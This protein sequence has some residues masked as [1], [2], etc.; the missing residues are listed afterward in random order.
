MT[1]WRFDKP[2]FTIPAMAAALDGGDIGLFQP[3]GY[4]WRYR[5][6]GELLT[7]N[8]CLANGGFGFLKPVQIL[9]N[10]EQLLTLR[11]DGF[12]FGG[13]I[14]AFRKMMLADEFLDEREIVVKKSLQIDFADMFHGCV[15]LCIL[16]SLNEFHQ[17][18][19]D[20]VTVV[21][22][23]GEGDL[24]EF[25]NVFGPFV[26]ETAHHEGLQFARFDGAFQFGESL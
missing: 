14:G 5:H 25:C 16:Q 23:G 12:Q 17:F 10:G 4:F 18:L 22:D 9:R 7:K 11:L 24:L 6:E 26:L 8:G 19:H 13:A 2:N 1:E 21:I 15:L 3:F 20:F